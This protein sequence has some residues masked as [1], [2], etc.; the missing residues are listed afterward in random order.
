MTPIEGVPAEKV[1][2]AESSGAAAAAEERDSAELTHVERKLK[3]EVAELYVLMGTMLVAP[4]DN[5]A[6]R[7]VVKGADDLAEQWVKL[8]RSQPSVKR[9]LKKL[10]EAGGWSGVVLAHAM[11]AVPVMA[12]R[13][14]LPDPVAAQ[15]GTL[16]MI[17]DPDSVPLFT[18]ERWRTLGLIVDNQNG[19]EPGD[20]RGADAGSNG[21]S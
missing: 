18:H 16:T 19:H 12:N 20:E 1:P 7:L 10:V 6:G 11:I 13:G 17:S 14:M 21:D 15:I 2:G 9:V 5:L 3:D 8:S 4:V